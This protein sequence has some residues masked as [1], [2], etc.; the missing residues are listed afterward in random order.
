MLA[1]Q[2][3]GISFNLL[4]IHEPPLKALPVGQVDFTKFFVQ[5]VISL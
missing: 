4:P 2:E 1:K 3:Q 5:L